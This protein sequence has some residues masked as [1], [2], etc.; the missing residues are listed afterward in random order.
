MKYAIKAR[1]FVAAAMLA[2]SLTSLPAT[3][4]FASDMGS[5]R[6]S[7]DSSFSF[8][9][10]SAGATQ[11]TA[12]RN[13]DRP[14]STYIRVDA[15]SGNSPRL[16]VDGAWNS[17]GDG[18]Y[19]C[20]NHGFVRAPGPGQYEI[21]NGVYELGYRWARLTGWADNGSGT[22]RGAW[23]PDCAGNYTDLN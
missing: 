19:N 2:V 16:Y 17:N 18:S 4:A 6:S 7:V 10:G 15:R 1:K 23:S 9:F 5:T 14:S 8:Y 21:H 13:K 3:A 11:A 12:W 22:L 20:T